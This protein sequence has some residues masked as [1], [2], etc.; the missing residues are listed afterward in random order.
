MNIKARTG[1]P[2]RATP[3]APYFLHLAMGQTPV[4][5][6][7]PIPTKIGNLR[8]VVNSPI[9][10]E[11]GSQNGV[12]N[13]SHIS[14]YDFQQ[15]QP[16]MWLVDMNPLNEVRQRVAKYIQPHVEVKSMLVFVGNSIL[17]WF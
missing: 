4:P 8:W 15:E 2:K 6:N 7:I 17:G 1:D 10:P 3:Q 16:E 12:D 5:V 14:G 9:P 11:M 13:H